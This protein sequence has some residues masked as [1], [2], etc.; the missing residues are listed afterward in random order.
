MKKNKKGF[1]DNP[2][3]AADPVM[4]KPMDSYDMVNKYGTYNVQDTADTQN[5]FPTIDQGLPK[6]KKTEHRK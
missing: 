3:P 2:N 5:A 1:P 4:G 6:G